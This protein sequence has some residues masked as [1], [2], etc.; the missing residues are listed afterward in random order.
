MELGPSDD[1]PIEIVKLLAR[2]RHERA[3]GNSRRHLLGIKDTM[4]G[5]S[6]TVVVDGTANIPIPIRINGIKVRHGNMG[7]KPNKRQMDMSKSEKSHFKVLSLST[8][9]Q[10]RKPE[11]SMSASTMAG[12]KSITCEKMQYSC[13]TENVPFRLS[14]PQNRLIQPS[15]PHSFLEECHKERTIDSK[16]KKAVADLREGRITGSS[17][18]YPNDTIPAMQL[19]SLMDQR[20][21]S[22][23][24]YK[25]GSLDKPLS[26]CKHH[27]RLNGKENHNFL[28]GS[29]FP[30]NSSCLLRYGVYS[31]GESSFRASPSLRGK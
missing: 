7:V 22:G 3:L 18:P 21:K 25:V 17:G 16:G 20:V 31:S 4:K 15:N 9:G 30:Q 14:I 27:L 29:F 11:Y 24:S 2:N 12:P 28:R 23:S 26:S 6:S 13:A 19:S 5:Y 10:P 1:I 8:P